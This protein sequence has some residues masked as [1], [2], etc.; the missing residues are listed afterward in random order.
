[1]E[2]LS[3]EEHEDGSAT[4]HMELTDEEAESILEATNHEFYLEQAIV[5]ILE[6]TLKNEKGL[7]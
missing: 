4:I 1:M 3:I 7:E 6:E 2:V 5:H